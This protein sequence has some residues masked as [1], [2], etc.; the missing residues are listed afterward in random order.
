MAPSG[1][2]LYP[3]S[4]YKNRYNATRIDEVKDQNKVEAADKMPKSL[5]TPSRKRRES[6]RGVEYCGDGCTVLCVAQDLGKTY[7]SHQLGGFCKSMPLRC[8]VSPPSKRK[9]E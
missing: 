9:L 2:I 1:N 7:F 3:Y 4:G 6:S 5:L 8:S